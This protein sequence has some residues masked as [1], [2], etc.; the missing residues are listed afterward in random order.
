M[1]IP[2]AATR[3]FRVLCGFFLGLGMLLTSSHLLA[4]DSAALLSQSI[5]NGAQVTPRTVYTE[6]WTFTNNGSTT[7][8]ATS[9]GY[10][11]NLISLDSLGLVQFFTNSGGWFKISSIIQSGKSIAPKQTASFSI[12]FIAPE[13][14]GS[15][16]DSF[17]LNN[18][19]GT[20]FGPVVTLQVNVPNTGNT[21]VFD[22]CRAVSFANNYADDYCPDG[23][24]WTN[25]STW[26]TCTPDTFTVVPSGAGIDSG[27]GD[28]CAHF[29]SYCIGSGAYVRGGGI[30]IPSRASPSYG[31]PAASRIVN[32]CLLNVGYAVEVSS[33]SQMEP[34]DVIGWNWGTNGVADKN[35]QDLDHVTFY[36]GNNV[37][38]S[39][40]ISALAVG[41]SYFKTSIS[42]MHLIHILDYPT[43]WT[44]RSTNKMTFTWTTNWNKYALY[45][46][47]S[48]NGTWTKILTSPSKTGDTNKLTLTMPSSG[49]IYYRLEMP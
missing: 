48:I 28:D 46:A 9:S 45:S 4:Q 12:N 19:G 26:S 39:H 17:S 6:T 1:S 35:V 5:T 37:M 22:R 2:A 11:L 20:N 41:Q 44:S 8:K 34:G 25:G 47:T 36:L 18:T 33:F 13:T 3:K 16:T 49:A 27:V 38:A 24:F 15:Y 32:N 42:T 10:T 23:Y 40:A 7:W 21:N 31:E 29:V 14:A 30:S 43:L